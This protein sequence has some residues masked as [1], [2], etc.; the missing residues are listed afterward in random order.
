MHVDTLNLCMHANVH[1]H[2][3]VHACVCAHMPD[4]RKPFS[5]DHA[6]DLLQDSRAACP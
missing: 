5:L 4:D 1:A 2:L 6:V 3:H